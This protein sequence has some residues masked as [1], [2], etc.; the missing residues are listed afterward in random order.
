[1]TYFKIRDSSHCPAELLRGVTNIYFKS[2]VAQGKKEINRS[3]QQ[4][5]DKCVDLVLI[6]FNS[7]RH[8]GLKYVGNNFLVFYK[9]THTHTH[10]RTH[11]RKCVKQEVIRQN[12]ITR[13]KETKE[14]KHR[15]VLVFACFTFYIRSSQ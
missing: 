4:K 5:N 9:R 1:M 8:P 13:R 6:F 10:K 7:P 11:Q 3:T 2:V 14:Q 15:F 12:K